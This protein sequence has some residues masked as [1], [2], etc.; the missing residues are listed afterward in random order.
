MTIKLVK[1]NVSLNVM[2]SGHLNTAMSSTEKKRDGRCILN[3]LI[4]ISIESNKFIIFTVFLFN[5]HKKLCAIWKL[6]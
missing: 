1:N 2:Y 3:F 5:E 6:L 4:S